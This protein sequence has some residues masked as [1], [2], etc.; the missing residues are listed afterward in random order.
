MKKLLCIILVALLSLS[1]VG[2]VL[3]TPSGDG[4]GTQT[5][6]TTKLV[7]LS[8]PDGSGDNMII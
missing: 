8:A 2:C 1:L 7:V 5:P 3:N 6:K 4:G